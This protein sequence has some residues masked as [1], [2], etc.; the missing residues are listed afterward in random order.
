MEDLGA[1]GERAAKAIRDRAKKNR[2]TFKEECKKLN[3]F[4]QSVKAWEK[5]GYAPSAYYLQNMYFAGYDVIY[6]LTGEKK[7]AEN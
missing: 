4:E 7:N 5:K 2:T 1:I 3:F 6:I